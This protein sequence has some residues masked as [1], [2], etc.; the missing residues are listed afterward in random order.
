[1]NEA[2]IFLAAVQ[3]EEPQIRDAFLDSVCQS[4]SELRV[5]PML[6]FRKENSL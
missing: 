2:E 1:M 4:N 3:I 6:P 5:R